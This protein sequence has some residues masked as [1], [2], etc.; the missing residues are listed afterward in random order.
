MEIG[1][2]KAEFNLFTMFTINIPLEELIEVFKE[3]LK[4]AIAETVNQTPLVLDV[5]NSEELLT[6]KQACAL[7]DISLPTLSKYVASGK[8]PYS[9]IGKKI[10]FDKNA[11]LK[12]CKVVNKK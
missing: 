1:D 5:K 12:A 2:G 7:L 4:N 11:L 10:L 8:L 9:R 3:Q 6:R